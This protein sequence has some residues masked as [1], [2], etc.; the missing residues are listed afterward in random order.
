[1]SSL[2]RRGARQRH[3]QSGGHAFI[4]H[5]GDDQP[6]ASARLVGQDLEEI[7]EIAANLASSTPQGADL[8]TFRLWVLLRQQAG[9]DI[10]PDLQLALEPLLLANLAH[11]A[12]VF[13]G[14][15]ELVG[16]T[17]QDGLPPA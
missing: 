8:P 7:V 14:H 5:I 16:N 17:V 11:E 12:R 10:A 2:T 1:M 15:G 3:E 13:H 6:P 9:L 4:G